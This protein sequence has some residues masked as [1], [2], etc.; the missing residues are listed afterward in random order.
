VP[1]PDDDEGSPQEWLDALDQLSATVPDGVPHNN[2][3][4]GLAYSRAGDIAHAL[5]A[6]LDAGQTSYF[7]EFF[8]ELERLLAAP[9]PEIR[10]LLVVGLIEDVQNV[11]LNSGV[12][13]QRWQPWL[14]PVTRL[15]WDVIVGLWAGKVTG[16]ELARYLKSGESA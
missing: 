13:L 3:S 9:T 14:G 6:N 7:S 10:E 1:G 12:A 8:A 5:V 15:G 16:P 4:Q 11:S 2:L